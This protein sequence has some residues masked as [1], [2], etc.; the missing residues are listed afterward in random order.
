MESIKRIK[1]VKVN[2]KYVDF[3]I[4]S[5]STNNDVLFSFWD[6]EEND[7]L[8]GGC[9]INTSDIYFTIK[10]FFINGEELISNSDME[11]FGCNNID[12]VFFID[13]D[14]RID[15]VLITEDEKDLSITFKKDHLS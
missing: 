14:I 13:K 5:K 15:I 11:Y 3:K 4:K 9:I 8:D 1:Y 12:Y 2:G 6:N 7:K 10:S